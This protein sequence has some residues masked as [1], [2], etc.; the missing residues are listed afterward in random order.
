MHTIRRIADESAGL[1]EPTGTLVT[2]ATSTP[3]KTS[4][5]RYLIQIITAGEG[6]SATYPPA[7]LEQAAKDRI[8]PAGTRMHLDHPRESDEKDLPARSVKDWAAVLAEDAVYNP[9]TQA[10]EAPAKVFRQYQ[11]LV[12]D[13]KDYVGVSIH[14]WIEAEPNP[15]KPVASRFLPSPHN[16]VDFVTAAG[17]GGKVLAALESARVSEATS[18]DRR[19]QLSI[20]VKDAY[21]TQPDEYFWVRDFDESQLLVWFDDNDDRCWQQPY[22]VADDDLSVTLTDTPIEVRPTVQYIPVPAPGTESSTSTNTQGEAEMDIK[23]LEAQIAAL[24]AQVGQL[25]AENQDLVAWKR[26]RV[27]SDEARKALPTVEGYD[28]LPEP[29]QA[30]VAAVVTVNVPTTESGDFDAA[31][32]NTAAAEAVKAEVDYLAKVAPAKEALRGFGPSDDA[33]SFTPY[34]DAWG[35]EIKEK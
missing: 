4:D 7:V 11:M 23:E 21:Q 14:A 32:F 33:Q 29:A 3:T 26:D 34:V 6:S 5:G 18:R 22:T 8:F 2:E 27:T 13:L 17:R 24:Q 35:N 1:A 20:A 19:E 28:K 31:K 15:G 25:T 9:T 10:L 30:R 12:E 16:T